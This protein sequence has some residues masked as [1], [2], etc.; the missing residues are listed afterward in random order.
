MGWL[1]STFPRIARGE[2]VPVT[3]LPDVQT[4]FEVP[5]PN[6]QIKQPFPSY[7]TPLGSF[8]AAFLAVYSPTPRLRRI[9]AGCS[10][11]QNPSQFPGAHLERTSCCFRQTFVANLLE[12]VGPGDA[13]AVSTLRWDRHR[14]CC[15]RSNG[16]SV[17][18]FHAYQSPGQ[19]L[20]HR[21]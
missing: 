16:C 13:R 12:A 18:F 5:L 2:R 3:S 7:T 14:K 19:F 4:S 6:R 8:P 15:L 10:F 1:P 9:S 17:N 20:S 21:G 11:L